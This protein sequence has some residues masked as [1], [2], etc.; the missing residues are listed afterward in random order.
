MKKLMLTF[1][2]VLTLCAGVCCAAETLP[3]YAY[4]GEDPIEGAVANYTASELG[5]LFLLEDGCVTI[6]CPIILKTETPDDSHATVYG[7]FWISNYVLSDDILH[8]ISGGEFPGVIQLEKHDG[9]WQVTNAEYA[10]DGEDYSR[11]IQRF[12]NGDKEL[13]KLY[14]GAA[15]GLS[16]KNV[17][18]QRRFIRGY[19]E[20]NSLNITAWQDPFWP[21]TPLEEASD[22]PIRGNIENG[23][24]VVKVPVTGIPGRWEASAPEGEDAAVQLASAETADGYFTARFDPAKDGS[25][26]VYI[27]HYTGIACDQVHSFDLAVENGQVKENTSGS[28]TA[29]SLDKDLDAHVGGQ[30]FEKDT[31]FTRMYA[32]RD[33]YQGWQVEIT[34]PMT[35]GAYIFEAHMYYDCDQDRFI[36][37]DGAFYALNAETGEA[38][39]LIAADTQGSFALTA[40]E[41]AEADALQLIWESGQEIAPMT[42]F[43]HE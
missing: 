35:H 9:A 37:Q 20:A 34:S 19:V 17:E 43:E 27:K 8:E 33:P 11:D 18:T 3:P 31:Q 29:S 26:T 12:A 39:D 1:L 22:E 15:D 23:S 14:F 10:G 42:V 7:T 24:Y 32:L 25:G 21:P 16:E 4:P 13:E 38:G 40:G 28:F 41:N 6:P 30:W 2:L 5:S 36:Y